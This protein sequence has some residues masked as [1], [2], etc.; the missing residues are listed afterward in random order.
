M[1]TARVTWF[2]AA[3]AAAGY[4]ALWLG[5][6][7]GWGWIA[8]GDGD[9]LRA[10]YAFGAHRPAWIEFWNAVSMLL[11]PT[12]LRIIAIIGI[13][14]ALLNRQPRIAVFLT[15]TVLAMG[16]VTVAAKAAVDRPRPD[17]ALT[18]AASSSFP[19]GHALGIMVGVLAFLTILLP[20]VPRPARM[21]AVAAGAGAVLLVG[22]ARVALNV[23]HPSD[24]LAGWALGYLWFLAC[25]T[26]VPPGP[27]PADLGPAASPVADRRPG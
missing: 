16:L 27:G 18:A 24:V 9:A 4:L 2:V 12:V 25:V 22:V 17:T 19:S 10:A 26:V 3:V 11:G 8:A 5:Q 15:L 21:W 6:A 14:V 1:V 13:V 20:R 7:S 23:H